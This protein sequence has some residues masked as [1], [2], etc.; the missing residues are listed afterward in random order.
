MRPKATTTLIALSLAAAFGGFA[1]TAMRDAL[2]APA[3]AAPAAAP[4]APA[5]AALPAA[6]GTTPLPSLAPM[7]ARVTPAVVSVHQTARA[8][9]PFGTIR[10]SA[11]CSRLTGTD[12]RI[13]GLG[14]DVDAR[15]AWC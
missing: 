4:A 2:E 7:L 9:S 1:A 13:A 15:A 10:S 8:L 5:I 11:A 14:R 6:V 12:Q 3:A